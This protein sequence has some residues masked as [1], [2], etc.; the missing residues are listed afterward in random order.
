MKKYILNVLDVEDGDVYYV[1]L[2]DDALELQRARNL[3]KKFDKK[4]YEYPDEF[5]TCDYANELIKVLDE[6]LV[7]YELPELENVYVR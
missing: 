4:W 1:L 5:D 2:F 7:N 3:I 6:N